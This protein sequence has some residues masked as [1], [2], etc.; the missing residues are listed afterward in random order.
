MAARFIPL[1]QELTKLGQ[2]L[3][4]AENRQLKSER[5][6]EQQTGILAPDEFLQELRQSYRRG[7]PP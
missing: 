4:D 3:L 5:Q 7:S 2:A 1:W 6:D